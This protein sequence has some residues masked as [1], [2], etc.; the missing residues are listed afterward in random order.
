MV[1][2]DVCV[3]G[4]RYFLTYEFRQLCA[5]IVKSN[6]TMFEFLGVYILGG[7]RRCRWSYASIIFPGYIIGVVKLEVY[8]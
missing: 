5:Q 3:L 4:Y 6:N 2:C 1:A 8:F 7:G